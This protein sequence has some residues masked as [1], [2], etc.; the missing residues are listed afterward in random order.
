MPQVMAVEEVEQI[1]LGANVPGRVKVA[2]KVT[3]T[4]EALNKG[5]HSGDNLICPFLR[6]HPLFRNQLMFA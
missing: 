1:D 3:S 2:E 6:G 5:G 4:V